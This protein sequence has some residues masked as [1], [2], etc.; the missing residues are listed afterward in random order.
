MYARVLRKWSL[1]TKP[2]VSMN[3]WRLLLLTLLLICLYTTPVTCLTTA[4]AQRL[5]VNRSTAP[6]TAPLIATASATV[7]AAAALTAPLPR[8]AAAAPAA[9]AVASASARE[10]VSATQPLTPSAAKVEAATVGDIIEESFYIPVDGADA[11][12]NIYGGSSS[13]LVQA[14]GVHGAAGAAAGVDLVGHSGSNDGAVSGSSSSSS[15]IFSSSSVMN[16]DN[17][18]RQ[19]QQHIK[20]AQLYK[21]TVGWDA[22]EANANDLA[23]AFYRR[24]EPQA[25]YQSAKAL[26]AATRPSAVG[27]ATQAPTTVFRPQFSAHYVA[28]DE[29]VANDGDEEDDHEEEEE[30]S[31]EEETEDVDDDVDGDAEVYAHASDEGGDDDYARQQQEKVPNNKNSHI[32]NL[33][34]PYKHSN[35]NNYN[36]NNNHNTNSNLHKT[37]PQQLQQ[38][39]RSSVATIQPVH[40]APTISD[41]QTY[42]AGKRS[43][44]ARRHVPLTNAQQQQQ[45]ALRLHAAHAPKNALTST[46]LPIAAYPTKKVYQL[47]NGKNLTRL[48]HIL[49]PTHYRF[50]AYEIPASLPYRG[51]LSEQQ[52]R[53]LQQQ[54]EQQLQQDQTARSRRDSRVF[55]LAQSMSSGINAGFYSMQQAPELT[56]AQQ[57]N[58]QQQHQYQ[59]LQQASSSAGGNSWQQ[60]SGNIY[61]RQTLEQHRQQQPHN[62]HKHQHNKGAQGGMGNNNNNH[63]RNTHNGHHSNNSK[64][65]QR[66][67]QRKR[68]RR[69]C[70]ARDPAQLAFEAP[71]VFEGKITS[72]SPDR[73]HNFAATVQVLNAYKQ[74]IG[75]QVKREQF[76]RLQFEYINS[77]GECDIYREQ[78]RPRGLVRGDELELQRTYLFFVQQIDMRNFTILG[79]PIRKTRRVIEAVKDA[80]S[81]NYA[82]LASIRNI[83]TNRTMEIGK[84]L[85]IVCKVQGRPPPKVTWFKDGKSINRNRKLYKFRHFKMRSELII[86]SFNI[87]DTGHYECRAKNK[88]NQEPARRIIAIKADPET[89]STTNL[90]GGT[91]KVCSDD[92]AEFCMNGG[93]CHFYTE[94]NSFSCI[95]PEGFIGER[96]DRKEVNNLSPNITIKVGYIADD[97]NSYTESIAANLP[98]GGTQLMPVE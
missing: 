80:V 19:Q 54:H 6:A 97:P 48:V 86:R 81:E 25:F 35:I 7:N 57:L 53:A 18:G 63:Q 92:A 11:D 73:R 5:R 26:Q 71:I 61:Q 84:E 55:G 28:N 23:Y 40:T 44:K 15:R 64:H 17:S 89:R 58:A 72:M 49:P 10:I 22:T 39:T 79:Q 91:G 32:I 52:R 38:L 76:V 30:E 46:P 47:V 83:T 87:S 43:Y 42:A 96:C 56:L 82:Q 78:L 50:T 68:P 16:S 95:C 12:S 93:T 8:T 74:Q 98:F 90:A 27:M 31:E 85:H 3:M 41:T 51:E 70:S 88:I 36:T 65:N 59:R 24:P 20:Q 45:H 33:F 1:Q 75:Y 29:R 60:M 37:H 9:P 62:H 67:R 14:L 69:Y 4:Y 66:Q 94:I 77:S 34:K 2:Q 13:R 21:Q